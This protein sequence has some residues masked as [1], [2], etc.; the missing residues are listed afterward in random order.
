[1]HSARKVFYGAALQP[2]FGQLAVGGAI[3]TIIIPRSK[4]GTKTTRKREKIENDTL[5][6]DGAPR[7]DG[8]GEFANDM[9]WDTVPNLD[10]MPFVQH[11]F[12]GGA[13]NPTG[14]GPFSRV[15]GLDDAINHFT[16]DE[17]YPD[18]AV[19]EYWRQLDHVLHKV[20]VKYALNT[21]LKITAES[22]GSGNWTSEAAPF[23]A[24]PTKIEAEPCDYS[25]AV[26]TLDGQQFK[27]TEL[28]ADMTRAV[29]WERDSGGSGK[30]TDCKYESFMCE[31]S[32]T[33]F[34]RDNTLEVAAQTNPVTLMDLVLS[35]V[36]GAK[37]TTWRWPEIQIFAED[38]VDNSGE[39][40]KQTF[41]WSAKKLAN[42]LSPLQ[43]TTVS[44]TAVVS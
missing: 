36:K 40:S 3:N 10:Y 24:T 2:A 23:D 44:G 22:S 29:A 7:P 34:K 13:D 18:L 16:I 20:S 21:L 41:K 32:V 4:S 26:I 11:M 27:V 38:G 37:S 5:Y 14:V 28:S 25:E 42:A 43:W 17:G 39:G 12:M 33:V 6:D 1:M 35:Y 9:S 8:L 19:P 31:G 30:A 15:R